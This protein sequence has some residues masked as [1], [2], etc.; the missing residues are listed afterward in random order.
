MVRRVATSRTSDCVII[1]YLMKVMTN[2]ECLPYFKF[3]DRFYHLNFLPKKSEVKLNIFVSNVFVKTK[4]NP[5]NYCY[6]LEEDGILYKRNIFGIEFCLLLKKLK[7]NPIMIVNPPYRNFQRVRIENL[8]PPGLIAS[9]I[10]CITLLERDYVPFHAASVVAHQSGVVILAPSNTGKTLTTI[11][12]ILNYNWN[13]IS[14]DITVLDSSGTLYSVPLTFTYIEHLSNFFKETQKARILIMRGLL[15]TKILSYFRPSLTKESFEEL[16][17]RY[18]KLRT[19]HEADFVFILSRGSYKIEEISLDKA[20]EKILILNR[21]EF[22]YL[23][24]PILLAYNFFYDYPEFKT[25]Q[26]KEEKI[27]NN[28]LNKVDNVYKI[29]CNNP[30]RYPKIINDVVKRQ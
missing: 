10:V 3:A 24:D 16:L 12:G 15:K 8:F 7:K 14:E 1:P 17:C 29:S 4:N 2:M 18:L 5:I 27:I 11:G 23:N 30:Y 20:F 28:L 19:R 6:Q 13:L 26:E 9:D 21:N 22:T 25:I